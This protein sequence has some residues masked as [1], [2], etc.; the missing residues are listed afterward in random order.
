MRSV[1]SVVVTM[2]IIQNFKQFPLIW[3]MTGGGPSNATTTLAILSYREA[4][5]SQNMGTGAAVTTVWMLLMI[6]VVAV[7]KKLMPSQE[8]D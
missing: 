6:L 3:T 8:I 4:F 2:A 1:I 7:F 5:V